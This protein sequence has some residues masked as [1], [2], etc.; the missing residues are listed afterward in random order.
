VGALDRE[1]GARG[2]QARRAEGRRRKGGKEGGEKKKKKKEKRKGNRKKGNK[3]RKI[4]KGFTKVGE[5]LGK[6]RRD[7]KKDFRGFF[8]VSQIPALILGRR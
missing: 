4:E 2:S 8:W 6:I 1:P 5:I 3:E 7:V